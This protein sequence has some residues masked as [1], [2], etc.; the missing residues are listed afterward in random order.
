M[1][2]SHSPPDS[3]GLLFLL[4]GVLVVP[5][6]ANGLAGAGEPFLIAPELL[7]GF[8][9]IMFDAVARGVAE[10]FEQPRAGEN[11]NVMGFKAQ[12]PG[13]FKHVEARGKYLPAQEFNL[14]F[15]NVHTANLWGGSAVRCI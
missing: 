8:G 15:L 4:A 2:S 6:L 13:G 3:A 14:F 7:Q 11:G 1:T 10:R 12:E 5:E 9:G